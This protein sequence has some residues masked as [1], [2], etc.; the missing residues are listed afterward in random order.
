FATF[1]G[2]SR[3]S[4]GGVYTPSY[5]N[6]P[7]PIGTAN[8]PG[9]MANTIT[10]SM[11][12][13]E[14]ARRIGFN[15]GSTSPSPS[16]T[17]LFSQ[18]G[19]TDSQGISN[20]R[21]HLPQYTMR[22]ASVAGSTI[23]GF[24]GAMSSM[25][26]GGKPIGDLF[27]SVTERSARMVAM[28]GI[29]AANTIKHKSETGKGWAESARQMVGITQ[30]G[31]VNTAKAIGRV[32]YTGI[33]AANDSQTGGQAGLR[34]LEAYQQVSTQNEKDSSLSNAGERK[35]GFQYRPPSRGMV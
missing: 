13:Q 12:G 4:G 31:F 2:S 19:N 23:G 21:Q 22:A 27:S 25:I 7:S 32:G 34:Q 3:R 15:V 33:V 16:G 30:G 10:A 35:I 5:V 8:S 14:S 11:D 6:S 1:G 29:M 20:F 28:S 24:M 18:Q 9:G 17:P 26:P